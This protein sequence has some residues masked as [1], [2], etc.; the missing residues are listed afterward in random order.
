MDP[1]AFILLAAISGLFIGALARLVIPGRDPMSIFQTMLV[2]VAGSLTAGLITH[3]LFDREGVPGL[4]LSLLCAAILVFA[5]RKFRERQ[6]GPTAQSR[7][8]GGTPFGGSGQM[9][10]S[11][12][13]MPG[14]LIGSLLAS[15]A[16][17]VL[18]N[19]ILR[20]F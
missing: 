8:M 11:V 16:L 19:L 18:L 7:S 20:A 14:C 3:Y 6:V 1:V 13:F 2:G 5:I 12:R 17:T 10:T 15:V 9:T 4:L